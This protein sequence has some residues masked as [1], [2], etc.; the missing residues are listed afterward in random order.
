MSKSLDAI[1]QQILE[2]H[3][4]QEIMDSGR[5]KKQDDR[6]L[7]ALRDVPVKKFLEQ[8]Q[9][10]ESEMLPRI[11]KRGSKTSP[12]YI[13]FESVVKSLMWAIVVC[14]RYD[15]LNTKW[16]N[17]KI[18]VQLQRERIFL[19]E[20]EL[21]KYQTLEDLFLT[22]G[23]DRYAEGVKTRIQSALDKRKDP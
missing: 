3:Q 10:L 15:F 12:D 1:K 22:E 6:L 17:A 23:L 8:I 18:D 4:L 2:K 16:L 13:F 11:E 14:D 9:Y 21:S 19:L 5:S 7:K 20:Q